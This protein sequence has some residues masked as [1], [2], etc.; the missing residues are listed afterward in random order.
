MIVNHEREEKKEKKNDQ[1]EINQQETAPNSW[2]G[3]NRRAF[4]QLE[5]DASPSKMQE[6]ILYLDKIVKIKI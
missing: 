1:W 3:T 6:S 4:L 2:T 5:D